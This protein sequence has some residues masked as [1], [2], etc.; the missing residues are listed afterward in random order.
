[1]NLQVTA[2][3]ETDLSGS[4][5]APARLKWR[6]AESDLKTEGTN[7]VDDEPADNLAKGIITLRPS[8]IRTFVLTVS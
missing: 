8:E 7:L 6:H 1:L 2:V 3:E 4:Q 5:V